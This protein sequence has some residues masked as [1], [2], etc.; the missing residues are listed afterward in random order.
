MSEYRDK[1]LKTMREYEKQ[2]D[3][4]EQWEAIDV[5]GWLYEAVRAIPEN[6]G[7]ENLSYTRKTIIDILEKHLNIAD[8]IGSKQIHCVDTDL[9]KCVI[10]LLKEG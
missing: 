2:F 3:P 4:V 10:A 6:G 8:N 9:V 1:V 7:E 5:L